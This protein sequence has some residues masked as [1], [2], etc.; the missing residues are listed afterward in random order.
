M[1]QSF[2]EGSPSGSKGPNPS[3]A[4]AHVVLAFLLIG[5]AKQIGRKSLSEELEIGEGATRT[6]IGRLKELSLIETNPSG[7]YLTSAGMTELRRLRRQLSGPISLPGERLSIGKAQ[8][9]LRIGKGG[10]HV[11]TGIEQR[12]AAV[13]A[14]ASGATTYVLAAGRVTIPGGSRDCERDFPSPVWAT[15]RK[16]LDLEN[17]DALVIA[18][19]ESQ[20]AARLSAVAAA[21]TLL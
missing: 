21:L 3:F 2:W 14:G 5:N 17:G 16:E 4:T 19:A 6:V 8:E 15:L 18:G 7:C 12:D 11:E 10:K 20:K 13:K 9:A 1:I